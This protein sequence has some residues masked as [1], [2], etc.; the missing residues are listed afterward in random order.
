M[1][2]RRLVPAKPSLAAVPSVARPLISFSSDAPSPLRPDRRRSGQSS[3]GDPRPDPPGGSV[4]PAPSTLSSRRL[5]QG[6]LKSVSSMLSSSRLAH[7]QCRSVIARLSPVEFDRVFF[8]VR[9][10]VKMKTTLK[11]F[12]VAAQSFK[13]PFTV[14]T[15]CILVLL[16][17]DSDRLPRARW[18]L[19]ELILGKLPVSSADPG[20]GHV[21][22]AAVLAELN[23]VSGPAVGARAL[24]TLIH[25]CCTQFEDKGSGYAIHAFRILADKG[26]F[27]SLKTCNFLLSFL[28]KANELEKCYEAFEAMLC[29]VSPDVNLF[30]IAI[31][32]FF[33]GGRVEDSIRLFTRMEESGVSPNVVTCNSMIDGLC[34]NGRLDAAL[35]FK[36][37]MMEKGVNPNLITYSILINGLMK[38]ER[39]D[40]AKI[41]MREA[42]DR[43]FVLNDV[44]YN[45]LIS[46]YCK[47]GKISKALEII[48]DMTSKG[49]STN[50]VTLN[51]LLQGY[52]IKD[53]MESA[54]LLL[55]EMLLKGLAVNP[56]AFN[57]VASWLCR[58]SK[59]DHALRLI[60]EM[61]SRNLKPN[62]AVL[63][64]LLGGLCKV[65]KISDAV[66]LW[67]SL[68]GKGFTANTVTSN[69]LIHGLYIANN[70]EEAFRI[71]KEMVERDLVLDIITYNIL[72]LAFCKKGKV[73]KGFKLRDE[74]VKGGIAA[75][76][77]TY[78]LLLHGLCDLGDIERATNLWDECKRAGLT[79]DIYTYAIMMDGYCRADKLEKAEN[80]FYELPCSCADAMR[81]EGI[82]PTSVTYGTL[83]HGL[84]T[85][86]SV[87]EARS[88]LSA[89][90]KEV[91][92]LS[93]EFQECLPDDHTKA[94]PA[95]LRLQVFSGGSHAAELVRL[96]R[97]TK[98]ER[99]EH[100]SKELNGPRGETSLAVEK[101]A[102]FG[103][104]LS[105]REVMLGFFLLSRGGASQGTQ[106]L[107]SSSVLPRA[108]LERMTRAE[109]EREDKFQ[110]SPW[111][112]PRGGVQD[113][114]QKLN[115]NA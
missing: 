114:G 48:E 23:A 26:L 107:A 8:A 2:L 20:N 91:L 101:V 30:S 13:F 36:A 25:V 97:R 77:F 95:Q 62:D 98:S 68:L 83:M 33:K 94:P 44:V 56:G 55:E 29:G 41:F 74:M 111:Y 108:K 10:D 7:S 1:D 11:F 92:G 79:P 28:V 75:D 60:R 65:G 81:T 86:G 14:R 115:D 110:F 72:I 34:K 5:D 58:S 89:M 53:Q 15:Y 93:G 84:C 31:N 4:E 3:P 54:K 71:L 51:S 100:I 12:Y 88:L 49:M 46:G 21:E 39:F 90:I 32:A 59:F 105:C 38:L 17:I 82:P 109:R 18:L 103:L 35:Q 104:Q 112:Y 19:T 76:I 37:K 45:P 42:S 27:P 6:V 113:K 40:E 52:I 96:V 67:F 69:A 99:L 85:N 66:E 50:P 70:M 64:T 78:N 102:E 16:L 9:S 43:G 87:E 80:L 73:E 61:L 22:L 24:D 47:A 63:T 106:S 57:S